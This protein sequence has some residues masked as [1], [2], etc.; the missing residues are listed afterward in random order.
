MRIQ[1]DQVRAGEWTGASSTGKYVVL[2]FLLQIVLEIARDAAHPDLSVTKRIGHTLDW[3]HY[4]R[5]PMIAQSVSPSGLGHDLLI[6][7]AVPPLPD[8]PDPAWKQKMATQQEIEA[9]MKTPDGWQPDRAPMVKQKLEERSS[10]VLKDSS[11][12]IFQPVTQILFKL[13]GV[14]GFRQIEADTS[15]AD[16]T[17]LAFLL[18][19]NIGEGHFY[20][21]RY[22]II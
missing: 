4:K 22:V 5:A 6:V 8:I 12:L 7:G 9:A 17:K 14:P 20:G 3:M 16:G 11:F 2:G 10:A 21:G 19:P 15:P 13:N 18:D 1:N